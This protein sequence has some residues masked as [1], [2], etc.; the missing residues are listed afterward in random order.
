MATVTGGPHGMHPV[1]QAWV[2]Q[3]HNVVGEGGDPTPCQSCHGA[4]YRGTVLSRAKA[5]RTLSGESGT[6]QV[7]RGFQIGCY[8]CHLGPHNGDPNPDHGAVVTGASVS[9]PTD[10][11]A[12]LPLSARDPDGDPLTLRI[13]SQP[14]HGTTGLSGTLATYIPDPG[15]AGIDRFTFAAWDGSS[16]SNLGTVIVNVGG[17]VAAGLPISGKTLTI[18]DKAVG[19]TL[20]ITF[21]SKDARLTS[22][23][24]N[25]AVDG[26]YLHVFNSAGGTD[27]SCFHLVGANWRLVNGTFRYKDKTL[28][29]SA[30]KTA[31]LKRGILQATAKGTGPIPISYR[32]GEPSQGSV[33]VVFTSGATVLCANFGGTVTKDSGTNPPNPGGK[34]QFVAKNAAAPGACPTPPDTCP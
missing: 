31:T 14:S 17:A 5:S 33:G 26:A 15:F 3:H 6:K 27:S 32:L 4:D 20:G 8:T 30:V 18:K 21:A 12:V 24:V 10:V 1:G 23:G 16:D 34:G 29:A 9:T 2:N 13:V 19:P 7:W 11:P 28:T 22:V 25:P